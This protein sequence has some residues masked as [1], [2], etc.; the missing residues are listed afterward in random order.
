MIDTAIATRST[1]HGPLLSGLAIL[2]GWLVAL[3]IAWLFYVLGIAVGFSSFDVSDA[4]MTARGVGIGT[5]LWVVLTWTASLFL[6]GMFASWM[7]GRADQTVGTLHGVAV[8]GLALSVTALLAAVGSNNLLQGAASSL[9]GVGTAGAQRTTAD[10]PLRRATGSLGSQIRRAVAQRNANAPAGGLI[11]PAG[12]AAAAPGGAP[13]AA[14][15]PTGIDARP[16]GVA[17]DRETTSAV[18]LDLLR[19]QPDDA[20]ARLAADAGLQ[21]AE[22]ASVIQTL[23][24][25]VEKY[26]AEVKTAADR[27][28]HY[29]A[30]AMWAVFFSGLLALVAAALGGWMGAGHIH[31]VHDQRRYPENP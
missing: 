4:T 24:P 8:W 3:G 7:D 11:A 22:A 2:C 29:T 16:N 26:K 17:L 9:R 6:G 28:R 21:P 12:A 19:D 30:A 10:T 13:V 23:A 15:T 18:A 25:Q 14:A 27:V 1:V 5:V 31:R 20:T